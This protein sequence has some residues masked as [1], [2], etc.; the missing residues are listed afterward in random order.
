MVNLVFAPDG[1][2]LTRKG[3]VPTI[4]DPTC[5]TGGMLATAEEYIAELNPDARPEIFGQ[6]FNPE[7]YAICSSDMLIKGH[8][9]EHIIFGDVLGD[10]KTFDGFASGKFDYMLANPPFGVKWE[11]EQD[12]VTMEHEKEG[13]TGRFGAGVPR[14]NDGSFLFLQHMISKMKKPED[15]GSRLAIVFNRSPLYAGDAGSGESN[16]R[17]WILTNDWLEAIVALPTNLFYNTGIPT[18]IWILTNRK[19]PHRI[20]KVQLIDATDMYAVLQKS[21]NEKEHELTDYHIAQITQLYREWGNNSRSRILDNQ[22]FVY[23]KVVIELPLRLKFQMTPDRL[24]TLRESASFRNLAPKNRK[25]GHGKQADSMQQQVIINF[26]ESMDTSGGQRTWMD[27]EQFIN[28]LQAAAKAKGLSLPVSIIKATVGAFGERDG[29]AQLCRDGEGHPEPD[30]ELRDYEHVPIKDT[31]EDYFDREVRP[32]VAD[33]WVAAGEQKT[34]VEIPFHRYFP[35]HAP[36]R[37]L[38]RIAG[39][40]ESAALTSDSPISTSETR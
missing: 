23:R 20:N 40:L 31:V 13:Y 5:G 29:K 17:R 39:E 30:P 7:S 11:A 19:P 32:Y 14:I 6:D 22:D 2:V 34:L 10:G 36:Q 35:R 12:H 28:E 33:A 27:Q 16:I 38:T 18:Y 4:Y 26:L 21:L 3:I 15:G 25:G 1:H 24:A 37:E 9:I 8:S